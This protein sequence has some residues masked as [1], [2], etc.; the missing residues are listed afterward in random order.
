MKPI[1]ANEH[2]FLVG[3]YDVMGT[4]WCSSE[5]T[6]EHEARAGFEYFRV[7]HPKS[8]AALIQQMRTHKVLET[9]I[10]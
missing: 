8:Q 7:N 6:N 2:T 9:H 10:Q 3:E 5:H 4:F 1:D